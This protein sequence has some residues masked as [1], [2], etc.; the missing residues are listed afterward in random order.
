MQVGIRPRLRGNVGNRYQS[1]ASGN[2]TA[3]AEKEVG[4]GICIAC[5]PLGVLWAPWPTM[6]CAAPSNIELPVFV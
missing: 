2:H 1:S 5:K 6:L 4:K 3:I